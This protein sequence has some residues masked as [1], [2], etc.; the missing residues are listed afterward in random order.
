VIVAVVV[1]Y[2]TS[3]HLAPAPEEAPPETT[4]APSAPQTGGAGGMTRLLAYRF[5]PS[6]E[7]DGRLLGSL[8]RAFKGGPL[9]IDDLLFVTRDAGT[10][11]LTAFSGRG[12]G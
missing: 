3:A 2:V 9:R 7:F 4:G 6:A 12:R 11:E 8:E 10:G 5:P 1:A